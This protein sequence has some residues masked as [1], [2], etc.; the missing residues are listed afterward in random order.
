MKYCITISLLFF[1]HLS[2]FAELIN[3]PAN[4]RKTPK[5]EIILSLNDSV[6]VDSMPEQEGWFSLVCSFKVTDQDFEARKSLKKGDSLYNFQNQSIG[7]VLK[8]ISFQ[9]L[10]VYTFHLNGSPTNGFD[11]YGVTYKTNI[12]ESSIV[13]N[14]INGYLR[15]KRVIVYD[16]IKNQLSSFKF[17]SCRYVSEYYPQ[18]QEYILLSNYYPDGRIRLIFENRTLAAIVFHKHINAKA[19]EIFKLGHFYQIAILKCPSGITIE[20][21]IANNI[22]SYSGKN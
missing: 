3:G 9:E 21:F 18:L 4:I 13:E 1:L 15:E 8:D 2:V 12:Y 7:V 14:M 20:E 11:I 10:G 16:D 6:Y 5:G 19:S 22:K 17:H